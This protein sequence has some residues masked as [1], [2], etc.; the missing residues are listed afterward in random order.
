MDSELD[1][2]LKPETAPID[3]NNDRRGL[4]KLAQPSHGGRRHNR[5]WLIPIVSTLACIALAGCDEELAEPQEQA[6]AAAAWDYQSL[7]AQERQRVWGE[8]MTLA[9]GRLRMDEGTATLKIW[10][11][12][13]DGE[14]ELRSIT[15]VR[16]GGAPQLRTATE[17]GQISYELSNQD[18]SV[19]GIVGLTAKAS[20]F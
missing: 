9:A 6:S 2:L 15:P 11:R 12:N 16:D 8:E 10:G 18:A 4:S 7:L 20:P 17:H 19:R 13:A 14:R 1:P 3:R 5:S